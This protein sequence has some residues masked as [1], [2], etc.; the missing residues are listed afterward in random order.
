[1]DTPCIFMTGGALS[2]LPGMSCVVRRLQSVGLRVAVAT[3]KEDVELMRREVAIRHHQNVSAVIG[4][5]QFPHRY[6]GT[7]WAATHVLDKLNVLSEVPVPSSRSTDHMRVV[8]LDPDIWV[9]QPHA[10]RALCELPS[11]VT[12]AAAVNEGVHRRTCWA[13]GWESDHYGTILR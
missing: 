11:N 13:P 10:V 4:W 6:R 12:F 3:R 8:W 1:M 7:P 2:D 9:E 5:P